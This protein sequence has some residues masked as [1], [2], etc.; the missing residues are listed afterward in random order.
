MRNILMVGVLLLAAGCGNVVGPF[1]PRDPVRVDEPCVSIE[2][3]ERRGRANLPL[4]EESPLLVPPSGLSRP[5][6]WGTR[7]H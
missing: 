2:E 6:T 7:S 1:G 3:Q 5:G 4:P